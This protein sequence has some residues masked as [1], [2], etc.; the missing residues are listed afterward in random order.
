MNFN[1]TIIVAFKDGDYTTNR[2]FLE[3]ALAIEGLEHINLQ[4]LKKCLTRTPLL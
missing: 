3:E 4:S 2:A 1:K